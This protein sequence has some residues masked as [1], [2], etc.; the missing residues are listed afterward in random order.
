MSLIDHIAAAA[1]DLLVDRVVLDDI[2]DL[3][4][5]KRQVVL[6]GPPGTGKT[7][8]ALRLAEGDRREPTREA[9]IVQFHPSTSYEDFFEGL[10]PK[11][12]RAQ[13]R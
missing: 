4:E 8:L 13:G 6:Y 3:L 12:H 9:A 2:V 5:D 1:K 10:R 7:F 11:R